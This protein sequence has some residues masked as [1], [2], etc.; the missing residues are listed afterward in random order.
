MW[1][2]LK[3]LE[4]KTIIQTYNAG[5]YNLIKTSEGSVYKIWATE[6]PLVA[7]KVHIT[8]LLLREV[9]TLGLVDELMNFLREKEKN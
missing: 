3:A 8:N 9:L 4:G 1:E 5:S 6:D 2:H 7:E